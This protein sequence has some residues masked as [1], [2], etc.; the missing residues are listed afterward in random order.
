[1][2][3]SNSNFQIIVI[4]A[5][6][7]LVVFAVNSSN[8]ISSNMLPFVSLFLGALGGAV[9]GLYFGNVATGAI[10]GFIA[11]GFASGGYD[12]VMSLINLFTKSWREKEGG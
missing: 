11:G 8:Y 10:E 7:A 5:V 6:V 12:S 2:F 9:I 4:A 3:E 1:M